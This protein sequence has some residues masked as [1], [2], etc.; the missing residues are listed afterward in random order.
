MIPDWDDKYSIGNVMVDAEHKKLFELAKT[1]YIYANKSISKEQMKEII[2]E[3]FT[4]MKNHFAH[5][6]EYQKS[7]GYPGLAEHSKIHKEIVHSMS[8][9]ITKTKNINEM[10]E[11]LVM[12]A[13]SWLLDHI[14]QEDMKIEEWH[15]AASPSA[16]KN[17]FLYV[18][19]CEGKTHKV[20]LDTHNK[21]LAGAKFVCTS[22]K[23]PVKHKS[24]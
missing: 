1:A 7:I 10:K 6:E 11:N 14:M 4:Y 9:L 3:F 16:S 24:H 22:C 12:I 5:E 13:K 21:I 20:A 19:G 17:V 15:K 23:Q 18:C 2:A 8:E